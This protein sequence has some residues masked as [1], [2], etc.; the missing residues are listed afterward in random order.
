MIERR[1]LP[2]YDDLFVAI[3]TQISRNTNV[4]GNKAK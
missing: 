1:M 3:E 2:D 4:N